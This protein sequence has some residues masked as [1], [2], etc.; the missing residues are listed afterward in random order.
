[1][2]RESFFPAVAPQVVGYRGFLS[3]VWMLWQQNR[4]ARGLQLRTKFEIELPVRWTR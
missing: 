1:M 4:K 3:L 2:K